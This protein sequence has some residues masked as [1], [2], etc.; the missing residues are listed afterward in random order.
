MRPIPLLVLPS[1]ALVS[2]ANGRRDTL[3]DEDS[4]CLTAA[5]A[6]ARVDA[7]ADAGGD[8]AGTLDGV[9]GEWDAITDRL[10]RDSQVAAWNTYLELPGSTAANTIGGA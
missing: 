1:P 7:F 5:G 6:G 8:P 10:G 4:R 2:G 3:L 9:D